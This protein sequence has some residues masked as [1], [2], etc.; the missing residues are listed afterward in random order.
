MMCHETTVL[1][2]Y[3]K[4][5]IEFINDSFMYNM[6]VLVHCKDG[7]CKSAALVIAYLIYKFKISS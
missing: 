1:S 3:F 7:N 5:T 2:P 6:N 4:S